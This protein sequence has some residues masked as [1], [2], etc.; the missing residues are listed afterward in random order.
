M[1]ML[2]LFYDCGALRLSHMLSG[3][4][5]L[6]ILVVTAT[7]GGFTLGYFVGKSVSSPFPSSSA[8]QQLNEG[9]SMP[10]ASVPGPNPVGEGPSAALAVVQ[11]NLPDNKQPGIAPTA[12]VNSPLR[13]ETPSGSDVKASPGEKGLPAQ[14][15]VSRTAELADKAAAK[16]SPSG[17][18]RDVSGS[19]GPSAGKVTYTVQA[20]A[21]KNRKDA[22]ALRR[23]LE[24]RK[25]KTSVKKEAGAKGVVFFKVRTGEFENK[26]EASA[27]ALE[28]K[29]TDGLH[30]FAL[31]KK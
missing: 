30:A 15:A 28:L 24:A 21:F 17:G 19:A 27:F 8:R 23:K 10:P 11:S 25:Y 9:E 20:G 4:V 31:A 18:A 16:P 22:E 5:L 12:P 7:T 3:K 14:A 1:E 26:K 6:G 29:N 13:G 2:C